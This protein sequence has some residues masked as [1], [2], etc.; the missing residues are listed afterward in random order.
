MPWFI[1]T[2]KEPTLERLVDHILH[3]LEIAGEDAVGRGSD[4]DGG[5][6]LLTDASQV[7]LITEALNRRGVGEEVIGKVLGT[8]HR[9]L[10]ESTIG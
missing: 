10:L 8:N 4:F 7:P 2:E 6:D 3:A 9:R 1:D 5:G